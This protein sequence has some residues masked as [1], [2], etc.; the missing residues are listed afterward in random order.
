MNHGIGK[1][2]NSFP[3]YTF[4]RGLVRIGLFALKDIKIGE[5][6]LFNYG[7]D[8]Q[9]EWLLE[10]N[11]QVEEEMKKE[12]EAKKKKRKKRLT[13]IVLFEEKETP[14]NFMKFLDD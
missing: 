6:I 8:Y 13:N 2:E 9:L 11:K 5:E 7:T 12:R 1:Y 14:E 10:Y 4:V 3:K